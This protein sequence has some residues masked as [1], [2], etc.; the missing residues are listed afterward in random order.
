VG[1][2]VVD[3]PILRRV[4]LAI[5]VADAHPL[6]HR[7]SHWQ[8]RSPGG[9]GAGRDVCELIM[10]AQGNLERMMAHYL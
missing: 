9:R 6:V 2:D 7:H 10:E 5:A 8:T 3:L 4:G 1:E